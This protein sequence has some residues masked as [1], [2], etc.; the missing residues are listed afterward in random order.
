M[1]KFDR[2]PGLEV[3]LSAAGGVCALARIVK[4]T[5]ATV[6]VWKRIP[7]AHVMTIE[8]ATQI[9]RYELRPDIYPP[10][11]SRLRFG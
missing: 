5:S 1:A 7:V 4:R 2:D 3:A 11:I 8:R 10:P 9:P 6:A